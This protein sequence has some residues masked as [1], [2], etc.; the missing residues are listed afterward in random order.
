MPKNYYF[1]ELCILLLILIPIYCIAQPIATSKFW[2][3]QKGDNTQWALATTDDSQWL[4]VPEGN[5]WERFTDDSYDGFGW[6]RKKVIIPAAAQ[7]EA[8]RYGGFVLDLGR[9]DDVDQTFFNGEMIA[10]SGT[11]PPLF[12]SAWDIP[13]HYFIPYGKIKWD[14]E[15]LIAVRVYDASGGGGLYTGPYTIEP[16]SW[17]D[18]V[19]FGI[20]YPVENATFEENKDFYVSVNIKNEA[21]EQIKGILR[22]RIYTF[23]GT[24]LVTEKKQDIKIG[25]KRE[26]KLSV[27]LN[28]LPAGIYKIETSLTSEKGYEKSY[29]KGFAVNPTQLVVKTNRPADFQQ[30]WAKA[31]ADLAKIAPDFKEFPQPQWSNDKVKVSLVEM[32]SLGNIKVRAW[33]SVPRQK[34]TYPALLQV[35]GYSTYMLPDTTMSDFIVVSLNIRGHGN[36][37]DDINPGFPGFLMSGLGH[38]EDYIYRGAYMDCIRAV[39]YICSRKDVDVRRIA[40]EGASQGG[41]LSIATAALDKRI[42]LCAPDVPFLSDFRNYFQIA[43]WPAEEFK[44]YQLKTSRDWESIYKVLDY[45]DIKNL[46]SDVAC[47]V[48]MGVGLLDDV[49]PP[50]INFAAYNN[51]STNSIFKSYWLYP[52]AGHSLPWKEHPPLKKTWLRTQFAMSLPKKD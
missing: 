29:E 46:A 7:K 45:F 36:S 52:S 1:L 49:C 24:T 42:Q 5:A 17:K 25:K 26:G 2:R 23:G 34:E 15:N 39:D 28:G 8:K 6:Y 18:F 3:F 22:T 41:A 10:Q 21:K 27:Q 51:L 32:Q 44:K 38:Q 20:D 40:V 50:A 31:K 47:P 11:L 30:F 4:E 43:E 35:Q 13:R 37:R 16:R 9:I 12:E 14:S 33:V 48:A 19:H